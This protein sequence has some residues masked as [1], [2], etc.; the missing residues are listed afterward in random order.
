[1]NNIAL[2]SWDE[3]EDRTPAH[4]LVGDVDLVIVRYDDTVSVF[5]G[6]CLHRGA[7]MADGSVEGR[8]LICGVHGW[9]YR[10]RTGVSE[11]ALG[12]RTPLRHSSS[13][14]GV[15]MQGWPAAPRKEPAQWSVVISRTWGLRVASV[16]GQPPAF[17][18]R[19]RP[20]TRAS[21]LRSATD[22]FSIQKP[23]SG[24]T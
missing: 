8:N 7:M 5:Y 13:R 11:Y 21:I 18:N 23:Q 9:D 22:R 20:A 10:Y 15:W 2:K 14:V 6:R 4:A 1:M 17:S 24:L 12:K 16:I 19:S 3:L